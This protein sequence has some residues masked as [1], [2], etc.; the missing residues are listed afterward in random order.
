VPQNMG[1]AGITFKP[2]AQTSLTATVRY[3][4]NSWMDTQHALPVPAYATVGLRANYE[5]TPGATLFL[6]AVNL[7]NRNYITYSAATSQSSYIVGQPQTI[8]VGARVVF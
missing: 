5:M 2:M 6:S 3:V 4:G 7:L 1:S 8:T